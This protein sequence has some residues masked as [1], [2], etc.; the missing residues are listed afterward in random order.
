MNPAPRRLSIRRAKAP[1]G[2]RSGR[3]M[4]G[5][6][7]FRLLGKIPSERG[8]DS[9]RSRWRR[10]PH[11]FLSRARYELGWLTL[12]PSAS[13]TAVAKLPL[14]VSLPLGKY[15]WGASGPKPCRRQSSHFQ[16][17]PYLT[18]AMHRATCCRLCRY[19]HRLGVLEL[20]PPAFIPPAYLLSSSPPISVR[21]VRLRRREVRA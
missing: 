3:T 12:A 18:A 13:A 15:A 20:A 1:V 5:M 8:E 14:G 10:K 2:R 6:Q 21:R 17:R 7:I 16:Q 4:R 9:V 11:G 19:D